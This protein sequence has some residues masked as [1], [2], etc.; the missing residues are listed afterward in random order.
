MQPQAG[1][2]DHLFCNT[3]MTPL[4]E[5]VRGR[6]PEG[7]AIRS[8]ASFPDYTRVLYCSFT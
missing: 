2:P 8:L 7:G 6:P 5:V 3:E 1:D 4:W